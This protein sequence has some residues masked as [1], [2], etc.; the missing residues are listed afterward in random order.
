MTI[1][2]IEPEGDLRHSEL[3][4]KELGSAWRRSRSQQF[5][6]E[7]RSKRRRQPG[8]PRQLRP[9]GGQRRPG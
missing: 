6:A 4:V 2:G 7:R 9:S 8:C 5:L 1:E 3:V